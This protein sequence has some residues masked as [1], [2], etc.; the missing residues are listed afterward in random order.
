[1]RLRWIPAVNK[2]AECY[3]DANSSDRYLIVGHF[4]PALSDFPE[5]HMHVSK[6]TDVIC[7]R[8]RYLLTHKQM[9]AH[10]PSVE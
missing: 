7:E 3:R 9:N 6:L 10:I 1:M 5:Q 2:A 4:P 8:K